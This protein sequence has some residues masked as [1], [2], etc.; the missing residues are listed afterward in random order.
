MAC[1]EAMR[2]PS[3]TQIDLRHLTQLVAGFRA[4]RRL[5]P[6]VIPHL[7]LAGLIWTP[8]DNLRPSHAGAFSRCDFGAWHCWC[9]VLISIWFLEELSMKASVARY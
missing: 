5:Q 7:L 2:F 4:I 1:Q 9:Q 8:S 6:K 3:I